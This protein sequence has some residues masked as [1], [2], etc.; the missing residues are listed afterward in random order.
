VDNLEIEKKLE[1]SAN[2]EKEQVGF[3]VEQQTERQKKFEIQEQN[4]EKSNE[5]LELPKELR[6]KV[7]NKPSVGAP[8]IDIFDSPIHQE[9]E[10]ILEEELGDIYFKMDL[11]TQEKFKKKGEETTTKIVKLVEEG[12]ATFIKVFKLIF[13][14]LKI[15]PGVNKYYLEQ[16]AKL[17]ADRI[18][19]L[20]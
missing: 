11:K 17:K 9:V 8:G 3:D 6:S 13:G 20:G 18:I 19:K 4:T 1:Q 12:K 16:E 2:L 15:I 5:N 14:W 10:A 7:K